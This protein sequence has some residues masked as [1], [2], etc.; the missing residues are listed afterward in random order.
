MTFPYGSASGALLGG[1]GGGEEEEE[2]EEVLPAKHGTKRH[3]RGMD[4]P[5]GPKD[6][7][8][9]SEFSEQVGPVPVV[10]SRL[11][12]TVCAAWRV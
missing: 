6:F 7:I 3:A 2:E 1:G 9:L 5:K 11:I 8:V 4:T 12:L 10:R